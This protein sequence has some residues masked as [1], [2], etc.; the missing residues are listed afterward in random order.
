L[1]PRLSLLGTVDGFYT[2]QELI[3]HYVADRVVND[4][5]CDGCGCRDTDQMKSL[6]FGKVTIG[7]TT[8]LQTNL[9]VTGGKVGILGGHSICYSEQKNV[10]VR[11][12]F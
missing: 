4:V 7:L 6:N 9:N 1:P 10:Y 2:L 11:V 5:A 3:G 12:L 8:L